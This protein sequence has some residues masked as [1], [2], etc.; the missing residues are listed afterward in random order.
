MLNHAWHIFVVVLSKWRGP[1]RAFHAYAISRFL[2]DFSVISDFHSDFND[3]QLF[4][5]A[6]ACAAR[7][8]SDF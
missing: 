8:D 7:E 6:C 2:P 5:M 3:L 4:P 1:S